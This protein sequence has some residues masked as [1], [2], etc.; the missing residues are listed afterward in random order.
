MNGYTRFDAGELH[1]LASSILVGCGMGGEDAD[2]ASGVLLYADLR[3]IDSHGVAH[4]SAHQSYVRGMKN[5]NVNP[6]P[7]VKTVRDNG[8]SALVDGD[9]GLG[10]VVGHRAMELAI[11][12][13]RVSGVG[14][15][16]VCNS[17]HYG[18]AGYYSEMALPHDM[19]GISMTQASPAVLPTHGAKR[20]LGTNAI[21]FAIPAGEEPAYVLD[22]ATSAVAVG[23][24]ELA[25]RKSERIP[26]GWAMD[27]EG[28]DTTDPND[29]WN[30]G[31]LV[32]LGSSPEL[33]SH[34]G[35]G[36]GM[37][38]DILSG[39]LTGVGFGSTMSRERRVV[40]HFFGAFRVD[41]F[42]PVEEFKTMMD[43]MIRDM[44]STP[45]IREEQPVLIP[46]QI[47]H[48]TRLERLKNGVPLH[49]EVVESL[50]EYAR[51]FEIEFPSPKSAG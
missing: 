26:V 19:I 8:T 3:G 22:M 14:L 18:C 34:K 39:V 23:K 44:K 21:S 51:E 24:L 7:E 1:G 35:F 28:R 36:L 45:R 49:E 4:L 40:G 12:K 37:L 29:Y 48:E 38:V 42:R 11:E 20:K 32:P 43:E 27:S 6:R 47:E 16:G 13:A 17:R 15:V 46:G 9:G 2:I 31:A 30:G 5:G 33:S 41:G 25:R 50:Q 10:P